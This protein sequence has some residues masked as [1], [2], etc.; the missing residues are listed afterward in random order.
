VKNT[1]LRFPPEYLVL[2]LIADGAIVAAS[3]FGYYRTAPIPPEDGNK[4]EGS[5]MEGGS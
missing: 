2:S 5:K 4:P 3:V 1:Y